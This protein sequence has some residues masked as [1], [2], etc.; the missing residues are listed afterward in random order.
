MNTGGNL[1]GLLAPLVGLSIDRYGWTPTLASGS[2]FAILSVILW[3]MVGLKKTAR[4]K[5]HESLRTVGAM[6]ASVRT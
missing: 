4:T 2:A 6:E 3:L 5:D 1:P